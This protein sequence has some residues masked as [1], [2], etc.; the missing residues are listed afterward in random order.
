M[1]RNMD[2]NPLPRPVLT[3]VG[4]RMGRQS[5]GGGGGGESQENMEEGPSIS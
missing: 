3:V 2:L 5:A 4:V 1:V